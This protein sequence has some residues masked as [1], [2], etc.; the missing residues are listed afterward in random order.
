LLSSSPARELEEKVAARLRD[1]RVAARGR[2]CQ[3]ALPAG[4]KGLATAAE[5]ITLATELPS[6]VH[7][8]FGLLVSAASGPRRLEA[9]G[10]LLRADFSEGPRQHS[11]I[12]WQP[13]ARGI[14]LAVLKARLDWVTE[15]RALF[16]AL[17]PDASDGLPREFA[18]RLLHEAD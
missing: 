11:D 6:V 17:P 13:S 3:L 1:A 8:P 7:L 15:R 5:A 18:A 2:L 12:A 10:I 4:P 14:P 9:G 16:G